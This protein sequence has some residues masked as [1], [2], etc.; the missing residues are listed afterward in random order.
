MSGLADYTDD[1]DE[2]NGT[3]HGAIGWSKEAHAFIKKIDLRE[4]W[5]SEGVITVVQLLI[6]QE[7]MMLGQFL[8]VIQYFL[9][10]K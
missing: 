10:K 6:F 2:P 7:E 1:I 5:K 9:P 3:L 4:V 8:T